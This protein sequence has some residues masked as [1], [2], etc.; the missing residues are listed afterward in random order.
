MESRITLHISN[1]VEMNKRGHTRDE[2]DHDNRQWVSPKR[3]IYSEAARLEPSKQVEYLCSARPV[4]G[5][6]EDPSSNGGY[7]T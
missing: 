5:Q 7:K 4:S 6:Q 3:D 2:E 1:R